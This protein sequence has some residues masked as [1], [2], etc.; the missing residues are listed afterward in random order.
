MSEIE[1]QNQ[2]EQ[3]SKGKIGRKGFEISVK[4]DD[5]EPIPEIQLTWNMPDKDIAK[6]QR[7]KRK[8]SDK[9]HMH[10]GLLHRFNLDYKQKFQALVIPVSYAKVVLKL[11]HDELGHNGTARTYALINRMFYWKG[12]KKD[13]ENYVKSCHI[14]Q[15]YNIQSVRYTSGHFEVPETPMNFISMD[16]IGEFKMGSTQGNRYALTVICMLT[17]YT[18]CIPIPDKSPETI[19]KSYIR[20]VYSKYGGSRKILSDNGT[21]FKN[22]LFEQVAKDL[23]IEHKVYSPP[24][25]PSSNE[26]IEGFHS[27][28]K[29]C[30]AKHI[31]NSLEWDELVHLV[32]SVYN[33]LPNEH[34]REAPFF[35]MFG[36]DPH[37]PLNDLLRPRIRY[38]GSD[39]TILSL[40]AMHNIYKMVAHNLKTAQKRLEKEATKFPTKVKMEDLIMLKRH[41]K[42]TFEPVYEGYY[43]VIQIR[44][45]QVDVQ[46]TTENQTKTV[47]VVLPVDRVINEMPDYTKFGRK[48]KLD[49]DPTKIPNLNWEL[50]TKLSTQTTPTATV[51]LP[52]PTVVNTM[53]KMSVVPTATITNITRL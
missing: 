10:N 22:K 19:V 31:S 28:L 37:I 14:C 21:E 2:N 8:T 45:N 16:L 12:L 53:V 4:E 46:S 33:F 26:R 6:I 9:Y 40:Q 1:L 7:R 47:K 49:L 32:C 44:G 42:K 50:S 18:W 34:S 51:S 5:K 24:Y 17:G 23:G 13:T 15:Q 27:F 20:V 35:L 29:A 39:E 41:D 11:A 36:R 3:Q 48:S 30:L 43:R 25:H 52:S 38:L